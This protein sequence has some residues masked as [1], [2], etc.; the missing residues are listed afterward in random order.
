MGQV[1]APKAGIDVVLKDFTFGLPNTIKSGP[2]IYKV[3][4]EG[5]QPH[6]MAMMKLAPGKTIEDVKAS[7]Q[8]QSGGTVLT[9]RR[10]ANATGSSV[11]SGSTPSCC[12]SDAHDLITMTPW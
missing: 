12:V 8:S 11:R 1:S 9:Q 3:T 6:E 7:L 4:N 2:L 5:P 10:A